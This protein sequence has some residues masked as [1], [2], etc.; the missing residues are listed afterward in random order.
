MRHWTPEERA[1]Q[2]DIARKNK[3]W[4]KS[5]GPKTADGK[6]RVRKNALKS[7]AH[8]E[9]MEALRRWLRWQKR[10]LKAVRAKDKLVDSKGEN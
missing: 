5:T 6:A 8:S 4:E 9:E 3:P 1:R 7:G 2:A 10:F